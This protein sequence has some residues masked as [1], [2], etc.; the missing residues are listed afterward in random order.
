M[1]NIAQSSPILDASGEIK[2]CLYHPENN[3]LSFG[4]IY[5]DS[6]EGIWKSKQRRNAI[7][8]VRNM[9]Y[10][11]KCQLCCKLFEINRFI[12]SVKYP[13]RNLDVN[14]L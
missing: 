5:K 6:L 12:D 9:K 7:E 3:K 13:D 4:N 11:N 2:V 14:F 8:Y 10:Y 1:K